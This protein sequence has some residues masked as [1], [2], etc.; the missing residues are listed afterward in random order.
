MSDSRL[1]LAA[2]A[3]VAAAACGG[4]EPPAE[5]SPPG[6][7]PEELEQMRLDSIAQAE[8]EQAAAEA[9][10]REREAREAARRA[11]MARQSL[12]E[13]VYFDYDEAAIRADAEAKLREKIDILRRNPGVELR[14][15]GHADERGTSE[16]N[17]ALGNERAQAVIRF[18]RGFGLDESRFSAVSYG[19]ARP[20]ETG[21]DERAWALN[22]RVE[23][24]VTAGGADIVP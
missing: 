10:E 3:V 24:V 17:I 18:I 7:S 5:A 19:E 14:M 15:E 11:E 23:F 20:V 2:L 1:I 13:T 21:S 9:A 12:T 8:A 6:P 22:R 16:Y 4:N